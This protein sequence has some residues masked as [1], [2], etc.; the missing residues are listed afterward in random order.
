V[1]ADSY[2]VLLALLA[3]TGIF[4]VRGRKGLAGRGGVL[5]ALGI[6]LPIAYVL[7]AR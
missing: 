5:M 7:V 3:L 1:V 6:L 4:I 2:A